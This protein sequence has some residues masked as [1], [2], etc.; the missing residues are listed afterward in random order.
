MSH[1]APHLT[2]EVHSRRNAA[3]EAWIKRFTGYFGDPLRLGEYRAGKLSFEELYKSAMRHV[4]DMVTE[5]GRYDP[6]AW[7]FNNPNA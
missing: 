6:A 5:A 1:R 4:E 7:D 2:H 3:R